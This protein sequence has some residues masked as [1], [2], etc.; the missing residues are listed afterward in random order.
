MFI[1]AW[2]AVHQIEGIFM[3]SEVQYLELSYPA[4]AFI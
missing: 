1:L 3:I 2:H 4:I